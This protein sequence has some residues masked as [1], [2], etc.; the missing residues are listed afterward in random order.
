MNPR[1]AKK[2]LGH[3]QT[4]VLAAVKQLKT[5]RRALMSLGKK[6]TEGSAESEPL[7]VVQ[8]VL[9]GSRPFNA[10]FVESLRDLSRRRMQPLKDTLEAKQA[11]L[12]RI[13]EEIS[14]WTVTTKTIRDKITG[15]RGATRD[16]A[17]A[18]LEELETAIV[19]AGELLRS[20]QG[21]LR[22]KE[23]ELARLER[24]LLRW[25]QK[26]KTCREE[27]EKLRQ[28]CSKHETTIRQSDEQLEPARN[29]LA[30]ASASLRSVS[31]HPDLQESTE[32]LHE[33][34]ATAKEV[35]SEIDALKSQIRAVRN[36]YCDRLKDL[37]RKLRDCSRDLFQSADAVPS[38]SAPKPTGDQLWIPADWD[39]DNWLTECKKRRSRASVLLGSMRNSGLSDDDRTLRERIVRDL[40][41]FA[42]QRERQR[43]QARE[44][45]AE[46]AR[47]RRRQH[48]RAARDRQRQE[49]R[50]ER[51]I[52]AANRRDIS[53]VVNRQR[54]A[55]ADLREFEREHRRLDDRIEQN[56]NARDTADGR[57]LRIIKQLTTRQPGLTFEHIRANR[58]RYPAYDNARA[59]V[60]DLETER[61][62]LQNLYRRR[63]RL[64]QAKSEA[65]ERV[66][67]ELRSQSPSTTRTGGRAHRIEINEW[68]DAEL[69]AEKHMQYLGYTDARRTNAGA[70]GG[71]DVESGRAVAQVK[72]QSN[73][74]G[75]DVIQRL[76]GVAHSKRKKA[77]FF[78]RRYAP[79]AVT[80]ALENNV[81]LYKFDRAGV[82]TEVV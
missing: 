52:I 12:S 70:D 41:A 38:L 26:T 54:R 50:R 75:R 1:T 46:Q 30:D 4:E 55:E 65:D 21:R 39:L 10:D 8:E 53:R 47:E 6:L 72:D 15:E 3:Y 35:R 78:A 59:R 63:E 79:Q 9:A 44:Q 31:D 68:E 61:D 22:T 29:D 36:R 62:R 57:V 11:E 51:Q 73:P 45:R 24:G 19:F 60:E 18:R 48:E 40:T 77:Y 80:W 69:L 42:S 58:S 64:R 14:Q 32:K 17:A 33:L 16:K 67:A 82:V 27:T 13:Q 71:V 23:R 56:S 7:T 34:S 5:A 2:F 25:S 20:A 74:V 37:E 43:V 76:Y 66:T 81:K 28:E 49:A